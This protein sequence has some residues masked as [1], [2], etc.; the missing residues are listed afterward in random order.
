MNENQYRSSHQRLTDL[1]ALHFAERIS[2]AEQEELWNYINDPFYKQQVIDL[3]P[4]SMSQDLEEQFLDTQ[5]ADA[6]LGLVFAKADRQEGRSKYR[7]IPIWSWKRSVVAA[8]MAAIV[9]I[10][11]WMYYQSSKRVDLESKTQLAMDI[12]AGTEGAT[13]RLADGRVITLGDAEN[14]KIASEAGI[15]VEKGQDGELT[16]RIA[17][18]EGDVQHPHVLATDKGQTYRVLLPDGSRVWLNAMSELAYKPNLLEGGRRKV[19]LKGEAYFEIAKD[20]EHPFV[21]QSRNQEVEVLG[22]H[23]NINAY[24]DE[25]FVATTLLEGA[26]RL[27]AAGE[28]LM[29]SPGQQAVNRDGQIRIRTAN[30]ENIMDWK[31]GD[32]AFQHVDFRTSMRKVERWYD[33]EMIYDESVPKDLEAGG[34]ISRKKS[35]SAV[36]QFIESTQIVRFRVEGR[37]VY[38]SGY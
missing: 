8:A 10:G 17:T 37:K 14:G 11:A 21:V 20:K 12:P 32:F 3:I 7:A 29:L 35:L 15:V 16:Y 5:R 18:S 22:T 4:D 19:Q 26:V 27:H 36:L 23:F 28:Q 30:L 1:M 38:V 25:P 34:W 9:S 6:I 13:L 33:V 31:D 2:A 24:N